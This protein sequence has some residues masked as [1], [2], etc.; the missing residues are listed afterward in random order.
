M[1]RTS[2]PFSLALLAASAAVAAADDVDRLPRWY[3]QAYP[4]IT[5]SAKELRWRKIPWLTDL[6][7]A[8]KIAKA[9]KRPL[10]VWT[11]GDDPL[12]RC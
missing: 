8:V 6:G 10:L 4:L 5:P 1:S 2:L 11:T 7:E 12:E 9:E 3:A